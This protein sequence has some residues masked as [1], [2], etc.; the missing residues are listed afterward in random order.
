MVF[1]G[2]EKEPRKLYAQLLLVLQYL[3]YGS[4]VTEHLPEALLLMLLEALWPARANH[5]PRPQ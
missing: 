1:V 5:D 2:L 4:S 3:F